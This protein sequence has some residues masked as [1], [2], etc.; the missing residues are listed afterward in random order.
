MNIYFHP[1]RNP[2]EVNYLR[3]IFTIKKFFF[4]PMISS[5]GGTKVF[6]KTRKYVKRTAYEVTFSLI[7]ATV[8]RRTRCENARTKI[9]FSFASVFYSLPTAGERSI[10]IKCYRRGC[11]FVSFHCHRFAINF[12][13][14]Q[15]PERVRRRTSAFAI[16]ISISY[17]KI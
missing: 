13:R 4:F 11:S 6:T 16:A 10:M 1:V 9:R 7:F 14:C 2:Y 5:Y 3:L 12:T 8:T 15:S 17:C